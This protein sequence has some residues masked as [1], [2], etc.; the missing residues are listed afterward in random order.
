MDQTKDQLFNVKNLGTKSLEELNHFLENLVITED[1]NVDLIDGNF[2]EL[3]QVINRRETT[4]P[5]MNFAFPKDISISWL[6]LE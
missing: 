4:D 5:S 1:D 2:A 6:K 3:L